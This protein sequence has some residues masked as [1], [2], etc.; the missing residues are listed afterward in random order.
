MVLN[1]NI[2]ADFGRKV[3]FLT[4]QAPV[5]ISAYLPGSVKS[6]WN[7]LSERDRSAL[8]LLFA[9]LL[10]TLLYLLVWQPVMQKVEQRKSWQQKQALRLEQAQLAA[11]NR[12]NQFGM[13]DLIPLDTWLKQVLPDYRLSLVQHKAGADPKQPGLLQFRYSDSR[14]AQHF[15]I[16][17]SRFTELSQ[18][19]V[20]QPRRRI[21]LRYRPDPQYV[22]MVQ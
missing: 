14:K 4:A 12:L 13:I 16:A 10:L 5:V 3:T 11:Y 6:G 15:L 9:A 8:K 21:T 1:R 22:N 2:A 20:D 19:R 7:K 18:I 17:M